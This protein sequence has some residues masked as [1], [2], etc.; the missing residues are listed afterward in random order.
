MASYDLKM[1]PA[2]A[3]FLESHPG[4]ELPAKH[5]APQLQKTRIRVQ[6]RTLN[7]GNQFL[8]ERIIHEHPARGIQRCPDQ[9][10]GIERVLSKGL[11]LHSLRSSRLP[12]TRNLIETRVT[13]DFALLQDPLIDVGPE[14]RGDR[15]RIPEFLFLSL[16]R[17]GLPST[18]HRAGQRTGKFSRHRGFGSRSLNSGFWGRLRRRR[19]GRG[20]C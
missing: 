1:N 16:S 5:P 7:E 9:H 14:K 12:R 6:G 4:P 15:G 8:I 18:L 11:R 10:R 19:R 3:P 13:H 17:E 20:R 2:L